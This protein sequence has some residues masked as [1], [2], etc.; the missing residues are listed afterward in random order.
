M[1][2]LLEKYDF[3]Q[4]SLAMDILQCQT[5]SPE[6][7]S[8]FW[9]ILFEQTSWFT[10][11]TPVD[12]R[13]AAKCLEIGAPPEI[14]TARDLCLTPVHS[15]GYNSKIKH[16]SDQIQLL[17]TDLLFVFH[18][19]SWVGVVSSDEV[20]RAM[21]H[22]LGEQ[23]LSLITMGPPP[24]VAANETIISLQK[25]IANSTAHG[26]LVI[27]DNKSIGYI[28]RKTVLGA[29][30]SKKMMEN[31]EASLGSIISWIKTIG[32][33]AAQSNS[34][35]YIVGGCVRDIMLGRQPKDID[36]LI[37]GDTAKTAK[38][39]HDENG[40]SLH[41]E[42][43]FG[44][45]HWTTPDGHVIDMTTA[46]TEFYDSPGA[47]PAV[48][49]S[50][51]LA[52]IT[53]RD[54]TINM[55][56]IDVTPKGWGR[57][58][59]L[60]DGTADLKAKK[61]RVVHGLNF[62]DDPTRIIRAARYCSRF[63]FSLDTGT[64]KLLEQFIR[65]NQLDITIQRLGKELHRLF[66]ED[67]P[68]L[69]WQH[70]EEWNA[71]K[72]FC[73]GMDKR[74][75]EKLQETM[76]KTFESHQMLQTKNLITEP[77]TTSLWVTLAMAFTPSQRK[78]WQKLATAYSGL[79]K[80]WTHGPASINSIHNSL[81]SSQTKGD[82]GRALQKSEPYMWPC[83]LA[84]HPQHPAILWWTT[85]GK[86]QKTQIDGKALIAMG[87]PKGPRIGEALSAAQ[88]AKWNGASHQE[89]LKIASRLWNN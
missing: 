85:T 8:Q 65:R 62:I 44:A 4:S 33:A 73:L 84:I 34:K 11:A 78:T 82:W 24:I 37:A 7:A 81:M 22:N 56:A 43:M 52:D 20:A 48:A 72:L 47:L 40:G 80:R 46:R 74:S 39:L 26:M 10:D 70:L 63:G 3:T 28:D 6:D 77:V 2:R 38:K 59:D 67:Y 68:H 53:R 83:L 27:E 86:A 66:Q 51:L 30:L 14:P 57:L 60:Y 79:Q 87:C 45:A 42:A 29:T 17:N 13:A 50:H 9:K 71:T 64:M 89:Q 32:K 18:G 49:P 61:L 76:Q 23:P 15:I 41:L 31:W 5:I 19:S 12:H 69:G 1:H 55:M 58:I 21:R 35:A 88:Y 75:R 36:F 25:R 16:V 54:F